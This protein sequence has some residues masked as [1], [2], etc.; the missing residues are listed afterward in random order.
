MTS[1]ITVEL[2]ERSYP[3]RFCAG[4]LG[5]IGGFASELCPAS[6]VALLT[7]ENVAPLYAGPVRQSLEA[8]GCEVH[9]IVIPAGE[10]QK[11]L[12][13][14]GRVCEQMV[15]A[16]LDRRCL[17]VALGGGVIG[18]LGGFAAASYMRGIP[19]VQAPT[20][21]LAQ[22]DSSVG[23]KTAVNLPQGKNLV[24]AF[25]QP[26]GVFIDADVLRTLSERD[27]R[28]G[29]VEVVK[30]G[31]IRDAGFFAWLEEELEAVLRLEAESVLHAVRRSCELK[32]DVV[33]ADEREGGLRAILNYGHTAG[34]AVE[35]LSAYGTLRHGEAVAVGMEVAAALSCAES[36]LSES[37]AARQSALLMRLG[38]PTRIEGLSA[39]DI[40]ATVAHDKKT[41]DNQP[42]FALA[43]TIGDVE[44]GV[45]VSAEA[46]RDALLACGAKP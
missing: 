8:A 9:Q 28:A 11:C 25:Y 16:G 15:E 40:A 21:L 37:D 23:G 6:R 10:E 5:E 45:N 32:A 3:I 19:Y 13:V 36:S 17:L 1:D 46:L 18:D 12:A 30:Y 34:H 20:T 41:V 29:M 31:V 35:A 7:D 44:P 22:V 26:V 39:A 38:V 33:A 2:G 42:R 4:G 27:V 14:L 24:G 43:R